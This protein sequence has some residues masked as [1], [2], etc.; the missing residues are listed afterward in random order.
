M[1]SI[2]Q[3]TALIYERM[4]A[5]SKS[6]YKKI[7]DTTQSIPDPVRAWY[8]IEIKSPFF[9]KRTKASIESQICHHRHEI[10]HVA[11][12]SKD[13]NNYIF[14][15]MLNTASAV[16]SILQLPYVKCFLGSNYNPQPLSESDLDRMIA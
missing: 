3:K 5:P 15:D 9:L 2:K 13:Y 14:I 7:Q 12:P 4:Y 11:T 10:F 8:V 16:S 1:S 6:K